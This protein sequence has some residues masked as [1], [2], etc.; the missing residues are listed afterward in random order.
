MSDISK[1]A[2][3]RRLTIAQPSSNNTLSG[4]DEPSGKSTEALERRE[5]FILD[6]DGKDHTALQLKNQEI[7]DVLQVLP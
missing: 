3:L 6:I 5:Q 1:Y 2:R 4:K 7:G